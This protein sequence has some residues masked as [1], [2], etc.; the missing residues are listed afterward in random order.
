[1]LMAGG[2]MGA[3]MGM[4]GGMMPQ[5]QM[6]MM[7]GM[8]PQQQVPSPPQPAKKDPFADFGL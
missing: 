7:G 2:G 5:Q 3:M 6:G 1:M 4:G 8:M